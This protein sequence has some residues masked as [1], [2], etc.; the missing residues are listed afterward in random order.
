MIAITPSA[1]LRRIRNPRYYGDMMGVVAPTDRDEWLTHLN[2]AKHLRIRLVKVSVSSNAIA[3][4]D[5]RDALRA[6]SLIRHCLRF[7]MMPVVSFVDRP[8]DPKGFGPNGFE[9]IKTAVG[10]G[11]RIFE[12][13][14]F[15]DIAPDP[16]QD[17]ADM[18]LGLFAAVKAA[19]GV[20]ETIVL[21][22]PPHK[23]SQ[24]DLDA[25]A[26]CDSR[27]LHACDA[28]GL[29]N[30]IEGGLTSQVPPPSRPALRTWHTHVEFGCEWRG[31]VDGFIRTW[32]NDHRSG[33]LILRTPDGV[34]L[35]SLVSP[36]SS[37]SCGSRTV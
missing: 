13:W 20:R 31:S 25:V 23:P 36:L 5:S 17:V 35:A 7:N 34:E 26:Q 8:D 18:Q 16:H 32:S 24:D 9:W 1:I 22:A 3:Q 14:N 11:A 33:P 6:L 28:L 29:F 10:M 15:W 4:P 19:A 21:F 37:L 30:V 2:E 27:S 12:G